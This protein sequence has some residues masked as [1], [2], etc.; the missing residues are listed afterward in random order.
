M[1]CG[2]FSLV[3]FGVGILL[4]LLVPNFID[5]E[6]VDWYHT[7]EGLLISSVEGGKGV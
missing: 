1:W 6:R 5:F 7:R 2:F 3:D 4:P